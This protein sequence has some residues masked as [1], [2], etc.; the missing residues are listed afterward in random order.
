MAENPQPLSPIDAAVPPDPSP[1]PLRQEPREASTDPPQIVDEGER[2]VPDIHHDAVVYAEHI[3]RYLFASRLVEGKQV[4]DVASGS[5]YGSDILKAAG[6]SQVIGLDRS[7]EAVRYGAVR[8]AST[9]PDYLT[10][11]AEHLPL[12]DS[13]FDV[14]VS[15]ET[16]EHLPDPLQFLR[17]IKRV[18]TPGG[19]FI[20][21]TPN[22]GVFI[23]GNP[24][25][26]HEFTYEELK[27]AL[28][29]MFKHIETLSQDDWIASAV[30]REGT[31]R[32]ADTELPPG[33]ETYKAAGRA[34]EDTLYMVCVCSDM[35]LPGAH[36][37]VV[38]TTPYEMK[39]F[40]EQI[41][42]MDARVG[43]LEVQNQ[44]IPPLEAEKT[45]LKTEV[46]QLQKDLKVR[47]GELEGAFRRISDIEGSIGWRTLN[48]A[49]P[50]IRRLAPRG[51][52]QFRIL[53]ASARLGWQ[54]L[55]L[56]ARLG[57]LPRRALLRGRGVSSSA[58]PQ[59]PGRPSVAPLRFGAYG[60]H[61]WSVGGGTVH[62]LQLLIPLAPYYSV[63]LLLPPGT[64]LRDRKWYIENLQ[65]DIGDI[66]VR[67]YTP[68][69]EG[70]YDFWLSVWNETIKP[71]PTPKRFNMVFFPFVSLDGAGY[72]HITN[73]DYT[74]GYLRERY[75]TD[76]IV[77]IPPHINVEEFQTGPK[78]PIILHCSR[79]ALPSPYAD[80]AHVMM[81]HAF[82]R[83]CDRGLRGWKLVL[84]GATI[85]EFEK[86]Y[87]GHLAKHA[88]GYPVEFATNL[89]AEKLRKLFANASIYWHATGYSVREPAAQEHFGITIVEGMASGA[90][91]ISYNS[92]GP[93]DIIQHG[94]NGFL[95]DT[96]DELVEQTQ[97][98]VK[99]GD[100]WERMS[101]AARERA[102]FYSPELVAALM[103]QTVARTHR[104]SMI[105]GTHNNFEVLQ[106]G[107]DSILKNTP[108]GYELIV[109]N[110][111]S[112]DGTAS[113]L[114]S[115]D[116]PHLKV[117]N[118]TVNES[119]AA[120]NNKGQALATRPYILYVND[121]IEAF[122]GWLEPLIDILDA[123]PKVG[124]VG[125]RL[126]Y[127]DGRVQCDGKMFAAKDL[128]PMHINM[129]GRPVRD[130]TPIEVDALTA[131]CVLVRGELAGFSE[132]YIRGYY[133]DT[134]LCLRIKEQGYALVLHRGSVL[135][136]Y[137][138]L[139]MGRNQTATEEAQ[140]SNREIFLDIWRER[141]PELVYLASEEEM[142][143]T[144][145]R[146]RPVLHPED[147]ANDW[148]LSRRLVR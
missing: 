33:L 103:H 1:T 118:N 73:S 90:V 84:A 100:M 71:A 15:F 41:A 76:D 95:F 49:R 10:A 62:A 3:V 101:K 136:H 127:P 83:L 88:Y 148:P 36:E 22:R 54:T 97:R 5:G 32:A 47:L 129:G 144:E 29:A 18:L 17:E 113:Y 67:H 143:G 51:S 55:R 64:Q 23:E 37:Q 27:S 70:T 65:I 43:E 126:L 12:A 34:A 114:A 105:M 80:K 20:V 81:I 134:D 25:H 9:K 85:D 140:A 123:N 93:R 69:C 6:A 128:S 122:P 131:A 2:M 108:P 42:Q 14:V 147:R 91:P 137:H 52:L 111:A 11:D 24:W 139:S 46:R 132:D 44:R 19:L 75:N 86:T 40:M 115:L 119:Y 107:V 45:A 56:G 94:D 117:L 4:L 92:G 135:I 146:C 79:F 59:A 104:V 77:V 16:I 53:L 145:I 50:I 60:E 26:L 63:E 35:P 68:N 31:M 130:E 141:I 39:G 48:R 78:E 112:T 142:A 120:F 116:Y 109:V 30:F 96:L 99:D 74:A 61:C 13:V 72:T 8:H 89:S 66:K 106:R 28:R 7:E 121:D 98:I 38:V 138:G 57:A 102:R 133:E 58:Q 21:S 125:P 124:A 87:A 82:K 110:N